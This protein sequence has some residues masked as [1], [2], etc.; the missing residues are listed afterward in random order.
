MAH[1]RTSSVPEQMALYRP[2]LLKLLQG[3]VFVAAASP[4]RAATT[5]ITAGTTSAEITDGDKGRAK[6]ATG[7]DIPVDGGSTDTSQVRHPSMT[8]V[9]G[10]SRVRGG[11]IAGA[12][13]TPTTR[14]TAEAAP[15]SAVGDGVVGMI[16]YLVLERCAAL[17]EAGY[18]L[19]AAVEALEALGEKNTLR[20]WYSAGEAGRLLLRVPPPL[21]TPSGGVAVGSSGGGGGGHG[22]G[23]VKGGDVSGQLPE[24]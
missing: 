9:A 16:A 19:Q 8:E 13:A 21:C 1:A 7:Q 3:P 15:A 4:P 14:A 11:A 17:A 22:V 23:G 6:D 18:V 2:R 20:P 24:V 5:A 10:T 12:A